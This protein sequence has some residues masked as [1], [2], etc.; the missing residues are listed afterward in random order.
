MKEAASRGG[1]ADGTEIAADSSSRSSTRS[2]RLLELVD[3]VWL[4]PELVRAVRHIRSRTPA[5]TTFVHAPS[6]D[7]LERAH[8]ASKYG[9]EGITALS[10][11]AELTLD[12]ALWMRPVP[13][14]A[15]YRTPIEGLWL[16]GAS[17]HPGPGILGASGYNAARAI[18][19]RK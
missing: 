2:A 7:H 9:T 1:L 5:F 11:V 6:L 19:G 3:P 18:L 14:L 4:D 12:Q 16:C 15:R 10:P 13:E 17:M 8:D